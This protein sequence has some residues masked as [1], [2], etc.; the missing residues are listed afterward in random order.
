VW[1]PSDSS[2]CYC[3]ATQNSVFVLD[4]R[5]PVNPVCK[6][7][8]P[9]QQP[10][11]SL[12]LVPAAAQGGVGAGDGGHHLLGGS[13]GGVCV[14]SITN[15]AGKAPE[16]AER[17]ELPG[18]GA[19][20]T[21][22]GADEGCV[23]A[24]LRP[25]ALGCIALRYRALSSSAMLT[26]VVLGSGDC[27]YASFRGRNGASATHVLFEALHSEGEPKDGPGNAATGWKEL[28]TLSGHRG[29]K[30]RWF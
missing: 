7:A 2:V 23:S 4:L 8:G 11:H 3:G 18:L 27:C 9:F 12:A 20:C 15:E 24:W 25:F 26:A 13:L 21:A 22:L 30:V 17:L 10:T 28:A 19:N 16:T 6:I 1:H 5:A 29:D 14:W